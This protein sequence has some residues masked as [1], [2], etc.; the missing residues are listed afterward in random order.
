MDW[1]QIIRSHSL[2]LLLVEHRETYC[3]PDN[4]ATVREL[5]KLICGACACI[6]VDTLQRMTEN[7]ILGMRHLCAAKAARFVSIVS[8]G[9]A[10]L[11]ACPM[12]SGPP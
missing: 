8:G 4:P 2:Q 10:R 7:F 1:P 6:S 12:A 11:P 3:F 9:L 5:E